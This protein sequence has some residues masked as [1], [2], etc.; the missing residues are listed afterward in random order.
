M[1]CDIY[2]LCTKCI[3]CLA[4]LSTITDDLPMLRPGALD[5]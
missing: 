1:P 4:I 2:G 3:T 5:L